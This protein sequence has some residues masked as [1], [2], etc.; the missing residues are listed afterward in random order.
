MLIRLVARY[1]R[2]YRRTLAGLVVL[3]L[4]QTAC[5]IVLPWLSGVLVD[6]GVLRS[7]TSRLGSL[8]AVM[9][10]V[11]LVQF[12]CAALACLASATMSAE[13]S[14][15]LREDIFTRA[16]SLPV[17]SLRSIGSSSLVTR[18]VNDV[19]QVYSA[20]M[21]T[22][23][24]LVSAPLLCAF[25]IC[26]AIAQN[27]SLSAVLL[28][29]VLVL[30][31]ILA[32]VL[33]VAI[34][35]STLM[36]RRLDQVGRVLREQLSGVRVIRTLAKG[37]H[38]YR[39]TEQA[40]ESLRIA[41]TRATGVS[42]I[43]LPA[44]ITTVN[45]FAVPLVWFAG[46]QA[47]R[48]HL[49]IGSVVAFVGYLSQ[50]LAAAMMAS[51][52]LLALPRAAASARRILEVLDADSPELLRTTPA[53]TASAG[54]GPVVVRDVEYRLAEQARPILSGVS[55]S[56]EP[57]SF[58]GIVGA[59]GSGKSTLLS[60]LAGLTVAS[61]GSIEVAADGLTGAPGR[62]IGYLP[63]DSF[64]FSGTVADNL[65]LGLESATDEELWQALERAQARG[66]VEALDGGL[67]GRLQPGAANLSGGQ[68]QRLAIARLILGRHA[69]CLLDDPFSALDLTTEA[70][71]L[72]GL[73]A[74][75]A[76][77]TVIVASQRVSTFVHADNVL[78]LQDGEVVG[79]GR[80]ETLLASV[81]L[82]RELARLQSDDPLVTG[83]A[84]R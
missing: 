47:V 60:M 40:S 33:R 13:L 9:A 56:A 42:S 7:D 84:A 57:G 6:R 68:R 32:V 72:D 24:L 4:L 69:V 3:E 82:Y 53:A 19:Q 51:F 76:D 48:G 5:A 66:V 65:R 37:E 22:F 34:A 43:L 8:G 25:A 17:A 10:L 61:R 11:L 12:G 2:P 81:P 41:A 1:A 70:A 44:I 35:R 26:F 46:R 79:A 39:R 45:V 16:L 62:S 50:I 30:A 67:A 83:Q 80:H 29:L 63:Q 73:R 71:V 59:T 21:S 74:A 58:T 75:C 38:E 54:F 27:V 23:I 52:A 36:Q 49:Q 28:L 15:E 14:R 78:V 18:T 20:F 64:L 31:A 77:A 55:F